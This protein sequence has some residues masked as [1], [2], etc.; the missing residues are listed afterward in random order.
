[1]SLSRYIVRGPFPCDLEALDCQQ[2]IFLGDGDLMGLKYSQLRI[3]F[4]EPSLYGILFCDAPFSV[5][6]FGAIVATTV[7]CY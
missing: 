3:V 2:E 4:G 1:M 6:P 7:M 5:I